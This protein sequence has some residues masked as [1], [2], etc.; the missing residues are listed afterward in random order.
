MKQFSCT[1]RLLSFFLPTVFGLSLVLSGHAAQ[2]SIATN[3]IKNPFPRAA[4]D[5][6]NLLVAFQTVRMDGTTEPR[7]QFVS[8]SGGLIGSQLASGR[9]GD[10][11]KVFFGAANFLLAWADYSAS[12]NGNVPVFGQLIA[13][14]GTAIGNPFQISQSTTVEELDAL[15][16]GGTNFLVTWSD[17]RRG[18]T[19]AGDRDIY[20]RFVSA[21]G[22]NQGVDF[23]I[24]GAAGKD[25]EIA[26]DGTNFLIVWRDD[27]NDTDIYGRL[28]S[29]AGGFVTAEFLIDGNTLPSDNPISVIFDGTKYLVAFSDEIGGQG[30]GE[31]D[32]FG[33][34]VTPVGNVLTNR[35]AITT[36]PG[37]QILPLLAFDGANYL[38]AWADGFGSTN[39]S[40]K[41]KFLNATGTAM[42]SEF[43]LADPQGAKTSLPTSLLFDGRRYFAAIGMG[44]VV[45]NGTGGFAGFTNGAVNGAFISPLPRGAF[46]IAITRGSAWGLS[47]AF[48]GTNYLVAIEGNQ[49]NR[50]SPTAQLFS[51]NGTLINARISLGGEGGL[52]AVVFDGTNYLMAW[53]DTT[54]RDGNSVISGQFISPSGA[55]VRSRLA[56]GAGSGGQSF[57]SINNLI[58][59]GGNYLAVWEDKRN[60]S[61]NS[62]IYGQLVTPA[63]T[64]AGP[65]IPIT[66]EAERQRAPSVAFDGT[67]SL[68]VWQSRRSGSPELWD[69]YGRFLSKAGGPGTQMLISQSPSARYNPTSIAF[70]GTNYLVVWSRDIGP[71]FPSP[72]DWDIYARLVTR[73]GSFVGNEFPITT[74]PGSQPFASVVYDGANYLVS[75]LDST[76]ASGK[77]R[78]FSRAGVPLT[79]E[80]SLFGS[81][82]T[83]T[84]LG[85]FFFA[86]S[87]GLALATYIELAS[88]SQFTNGNVYGLALPQTRLDFAAPVANGQVPLR[89]TGMPGVTYTIQGTSDL[90]SAGTVWTTLATSNSLSGTFN[91]TPT[92]APGSS[93]RLYRALLP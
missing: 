32:V 22:A 43:I 72:D 1:R 85:S 23:K 27:V 53:E 26:F 35:I 2:F 66:T 82:G 44:E 45:T 49:T 21:L 28:M 81:Q 41:A 3:A 80:F 9:T 67:N 51:P 31:W 68:V 24:S 15:S 77:S 6:T 65:E 61:A 52:P 7:A 78:F 12:A 40:N 75:W 90:L 89:F 84:Q 54:A 16:F 5:G 42:S 71:G 48:D 58:F 63:G 14:S 4:F 79:T 69:T 70:D 25:S 13:A 60:G 47:A 34:F 30:T 83:R 64:L 59:D 86:G 18:G 39:F 46:P 33:R 87:R 37:S 93:R 57:G 91:F 62:D 55:L 50:T 88:F 29:P 38:V 20:G 74:A 36:A 76:T 8:S 19:G 73:S 11:P 56:I 92:N 17:R 10:P